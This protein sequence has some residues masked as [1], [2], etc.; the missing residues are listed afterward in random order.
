M[1]KSTTPETVEKKSTE[2]VD[3]KVMSL[4]EYAANTSREDI[5]D[6]LQ[7]GFRVW[8]KTA[9]NQ[10]LRARSL[11]EWDELFDEYLKS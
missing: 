6:V 4:G 11:S 9:K 10:P 5:T 2:K 3:K 1:A 7:A 8:M